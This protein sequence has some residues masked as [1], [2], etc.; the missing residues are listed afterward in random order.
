MS[1]VASA[2][3]EPSVS[4]PARPLVLPDGRFEATMIVGVERVPRDD[5]G[6]N[7]SFVDVG[8]DLRTSAAGFEISG[9]AVIGLYAST[10]ATIMPSL[11][12]LDGLSL[13]LRRQLLPD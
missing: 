10:D 2:D 13:A 12:T 3:P 1:T 4:L 5:M 6:A 7:A 8:A 9:G 11:E